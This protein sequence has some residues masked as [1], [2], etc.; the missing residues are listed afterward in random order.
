MMESRKRLVFLHVFLLSVLMLVNTAVCFGKGEVLFEDDFEAAEID[1]DLWIPAPTWVITDG[2][3]DA[4][5]GEVAGLTVKDDFTDF[6][7]SFDFNMVSVLYAAEPVLRA[8]G[9]DALYLFQ[10]VADGRHQFWPTTRVD[11]QWQVAKIADESG[12][13]PVLNKW[14]SL[15]I[16]ADGGRFDCY[17]NERGE[18]LKFAFT[19]EDDNYGEGAIG[20]RELGGEHCLYDNV[21]V[22]TIGYSAAVN[23][24][25]NL[26]TTWGK[27]KVLSYSHD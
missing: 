15:R 5:G 3:L 16:I 23:L 4:N 17:Y 22:T 8:K 19:W 20:F 14:Y 6:D 26:S 10:I 13:N 25:D 24:K 21:L 11:G 27:L 18:E 9:Q 2:V 7:Y 12:V 1:E